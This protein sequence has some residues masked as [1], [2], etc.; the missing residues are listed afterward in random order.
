M[1][2]AY[3]CEICEEKPTWRLDR[4]GDAVV[5]WACNQHLAGVAHGLQRDHEKT[6]IT[7][8]LAATP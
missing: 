1:S 2:R 5:S 7:I 6:L 8:Y 3:L 4:H